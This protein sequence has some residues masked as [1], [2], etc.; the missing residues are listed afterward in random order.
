MAGLEPYGVEGAPAA[1]L[2]WAARRP[3]YCALGSERGAFLPTLEDAPGRYLR[4][5]E[6]AWTMAASPARGRTPSGLVGTT[7]R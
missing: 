5:S 7:D 2:E 4:E 3:N 1:A 6:M